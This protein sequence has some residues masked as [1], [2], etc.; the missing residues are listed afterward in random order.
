MAEFHAPQDVYTGRG[1]RKA[2]GDSV[3]KL[4]GSRAL[5][6][7]DPHVI[8]SAAAQD[9]L[10]LLENAGVATIQYDGVIAEPT[11]EMVE[12]G[13]KVFHSSNSDIVIGLG[14]GSPMDAAKA[15]AVR[16][17][18]ANSSLPKL[19]GA[20]KVQTGRPPLI[21][22]STTA[23]TGAEVTP[24]SIITDEERD[25]K[26]LISSLELLPD[27]SFS[28]PALADTA[29]LR[30]SIYAGVDA[31]TH[32]IEAY[33]SR[34][35]QPI[36]DDLALAAIRRISASIV[37]ACSEDYDEEARD[38]MTFASMQAGMAFANSSVALVHGMARP[39]G[40]VFHL[41]HG[42]CNSILLQSVMAFSLGSAPQ[43]YASIAE[44]LGCEVGGLDSITAANCGIDK[45]REITEILAV[46]TLSQTGADLDLFERSVVKMAE[47]AIASGSPGNNPRIATIDEITELYRQNY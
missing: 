4:G 22:L 3:T 2:I 45:V 13:L 25:V 24:F 26:M 7:T 1:C 37:R 17:V 31:L 12:A 36:T 6:V 30:P 38:D 47:D 16:A 40:A 9:V 15:I 33:V 11:V 19:E 20:N 27:V 28:D 42:L 39:I 46:P 44:A 29:P 23:G 32:A 35:A 34:K 41:P 10:E 14:G 21:C 8:A 43:R 5:V 18:S